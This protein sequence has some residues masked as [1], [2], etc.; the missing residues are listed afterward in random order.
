M[1]HEIVACHADGKGLYCAGMLD[2]WMHN[3][4]TALVTA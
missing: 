3:L 1:N 4:I 2:R